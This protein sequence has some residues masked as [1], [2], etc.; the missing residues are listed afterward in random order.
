MTRKYLLLI[1]LA[2]LTGCSGGGDSSPVP[3]SASTPAV[4][5][6]MLTATPQ[7]LL[8]GKASGE[9]QQLIFAHANL[10]RETVV[11]SEGHV[12]YSRP[13]PIQTQAFFPQSDIWTVHTDGTG[14]QALI[15]TPND[16]TIEA[17]NGPWL[18]YLKK[19]SGGNEEQRSVRLDTG[20]QF[21]I[22][23]PLEFGV[24]RVQFQNENRIIISGEHEIRSFTTTGTDRIN[25]AFAD[26][27]DIRGPQLYPAMHDKDH[28]V[29]V[30]TFDT[31]G[32]VGNVFS[33]PLVGGVPIALDDEKAYVFL[34]GIVGSRVIYHRCESIAN[35]AISIGPC[36]V[37]SV[38][39]DGGNKAIL[40]S[41]P[42][43]E[44][45]QGFTTDQV[46]IRRNLSGNDQL[47]AVPVAGG[48]EKL[49]TTL[50]D[51]EFVDLVA[52]DVLI[53]RR[54]SGTWSQDL[55]GKLTKLGTVVGDSGFI[56]VGNAVCV[57]KVTAVWCMPLDGSGAQVK[58]ADNGKVV[59][60]L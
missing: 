11:V 50:T 13:Q 24:D 54:P 45:V 58:I 6:D 48:P 32:S 14:D 28:L 46:I 44:A 15:N 1:G 12:V 57:T 31:Q 52:G 37:V 22:T 4:Q 36:D 21:H 41:Q 40:A 10:Q 7:G 55:N 9:G 47:I 51:S 49:L 56:A 17:V 26:I 34:K 3:P 25:Y 35:P 39:T 16:E 43:N 20:A 29:F 23:S 53:I 19:D 30:S 18:I 27:T 42:A 59:G 2:L 60:V 8:R 38:Q 33:V 5:P